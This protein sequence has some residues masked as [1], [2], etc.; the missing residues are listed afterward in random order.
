MLHTAAHKTDMQAKMHAL[1]AF[2]AA[3]RNELGH[4]DAKVHPMSIG[5]FVQAAAAPRA[6]LCVCVCVCVHLVSHQ[7][8]ASASPLRRRAAAA[9]ACGWLLP[10]CCTACTTG[11]R[12]DGTT[13]S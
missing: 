2:K 1:M 7:L 8:S 4:R 3:G 5:A 9:L 13:D 6:T 11:R 12:D 10:S